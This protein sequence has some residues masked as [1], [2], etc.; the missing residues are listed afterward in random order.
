MQRKY[1]KILVY[2]ALTIESAAWIV[3]SG[4]NVLKVQTLSDSYRL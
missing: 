4:Q 1:S 2:A 3:T